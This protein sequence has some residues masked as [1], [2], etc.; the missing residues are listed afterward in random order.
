MG[1]LNNS[2]ILPNAFEILMGILSLETALFMLY[3]LY[4]RIR[5]KDAYVRLFVHPREI[6]CRSKGS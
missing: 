5:F 3:P 1:P 2:F 6:D 4:R